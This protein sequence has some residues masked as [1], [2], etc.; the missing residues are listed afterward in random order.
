ME[1][2]DTSLVRLVDRLLPDGRRQVAVSWVA[3][4]LLPREAAVE[5]A[6][7]IDP[8][9]SERVRW[10]LE[11]YAEFRAD[12]AT[13]LALTV[14]HSMATMGR[15]LFTAVFAAG[16]PATIWAQA[17]LVGLPRLRVEVDADPVD[18]PGLP[19]ELL[20]DP[21][22]DQPLVV[23]VGQFVRTHR[24]TAAAARLPQ[25]HEGPLRVLLAICRPDADRDVPFRSI[26]SRVV[27]A[28]VDRLPELH[29]DVLRPPTL[30]QLDAVLDAAGAS[31][32]PYDVVHFDGHGVYDDVAGIEDDGGA[33]GAATSAAMSVFET[34]STSGIN[35]AAPARRGSHGY[36][37]FEDPD[38]PTNR[39]LVDGPTMASVLTRHGT[40]VL[41]LNAC[42]SAY[43]DADAGPDHEPDAGT[44]GPGEVHNRV[45]AY[46]SLAAEVADAGVPGVVAMRY[47]VFVD[48]AAQFV[49]DLYAHLASG[50]SLGTAVTTARRA[51]AGHPT[52]DIGGAPVA[53]QD[54]VVP[55]VYEAVPLVLHTPTPAAAPT[56]KI[57]VTPRRPATPNAVAVPSAPDFG[58]L[59]RDETLL[60]LD[61]AFDSHQIALMHA[62]AGAGKSATAAEFARWYAATGGL[63]LPNDLTIPDG[64]GGQSRSGPLLWTSFEH[65]TPLARILDTAGAAFEP[66]LAA[67]GMPWATIID[68]AIRRSVIEQLLAQVPVLWVWDNVEPVAGFPT[69]T[70]SAWTQ[71]EQDELGTFLRG[72]AAD[73]RAKV[74]LTSRRTESDSAWLGDLPVR[75]QLPPMPMWERLQFVHALLTHLA[76]HPSSARRVQV[77]WR[78]LLRFTGGNPLTITVSIRQLLRRIPSPTSD[79]VRQFAASVGAGQA[80][81]EDAADAD[82]GRERSLTASLDYGFR[83][84][85]TPTDHARLALL[86]LFRETVNANALR[87]MGDR[88]ACGADAVPALHGATLQSVVT[89]LDRAGQVGI[90]TV[91]G[92]GYYGIHPAL[93]WYFHSLYESHYPTP[94]AR[95]AAE[96]AY[97]HVLADLGQHCF[98]EFE[99]GR[100]AQALP[101]LRKEE[102]NLRH[103]LRLSREHARPNDVV[104]CV[105]GLYQLLNL[106]GRKSELESLVHDVEP[107]FLD[108]ATDR[109]HP[110]C[111]PEHYAVFLGFRMRIA[112]DRH[113][114][115][116][117]KRLL[118]IDLSIARDEASA[119]LDVPRAQLDEAGRERIRDLATSEFAVGRLLCEQRDP[120]CA[121]HL[122]TAFD[123]AARIDDTTLQASSAMVLGNAYEAVAGLKDATEAVRWRRTG[124][125]LTPATDRIGRAAAVFGLAN[126]NFLAADDEGALDDVRA[127]ALEEARKGYLQVLDMLPPDHHEFRAAAHGQLGNV[128]RVRRD[129]A[130]ALQHFQKALLHEE[131]RNDLAGAGDTRYNIAHLLA[132]GRRT[133]DALLYARAALASYQAVGEGVHDKAAAAQDLVHRLE[134][135]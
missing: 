74:L 86:C 18:V 90:V 30:R 6:F 32:R 8:A 62:P 118:E 31:G 132:D 2:D 42:R 65:H 67:Q 80:L 27:R 127:D 64:Q 22:T 97:A 40:P 82:Q 70:P 49:A 107:D 128:Y 117:A 133:A 58:F 79:E 114:W 28:G 101:M 63:T 130:T 126:S 115:P 39:Q 88:A 9:T 103:A 13:Q 16:D 121:A 99:A 33:E 66:L 123:L 110:G 61:R 57:S 78:P 76:P 91:D 68:D 77:D 131:V 14:E 54:W 35:L 21:V 47:N 60:A 44:S 12:P 69:D 37:L 43:A 122:Q 3:P 95:R 52:R 106:S 51:L 55:T 73:T 53:L 10:Y 81:L 50:R 109:P 46:G 45:R 92:N 105:Q 29:F 96:R 1:T 5:T 100:A 108:P 104:R 135:S 119:L 38:D 116:A 41:M 59:G 113:D 23:S 102:Q 11:E 24:R 111:A 89:L 36:L 72:L 19:W 71:A 129:S 87:F 125:A 75:V 17:S 84:A 4:G 134:R 83:E 7:A 34:T 48:T 26:A 124:L 94:E 25:A 112:R 120:S 85:F 20:R 15:D 98:L 56:V 93:P